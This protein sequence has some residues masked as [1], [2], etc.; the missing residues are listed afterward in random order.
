MTILVCSFLAMELYCAS[1]I[2]NKMFILDE[3]AWKNASKFFIF[4]NVYKNPKLLYFFS[5]HEYYIFFT[6]SV[7]NNLVYFDIDQGHKGENYNDLHE[8]KKL[9]KQL[10][11]YY[12]VW[13]I[14]K[15][16]VWSF[17]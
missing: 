11:V 17:H 15:R 12:K 5:F 9:K 10:R 1:L 2:R 8:L 3:I 14:L 6:L 7:M 4:N 16:F 13:Q